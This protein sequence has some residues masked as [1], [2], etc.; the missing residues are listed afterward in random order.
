MQESTTNGLQATSGPW[1][2]WVRL[3]ELQVF[4][5]ACIAALPTL[6]SLLSALYSLAVVQ[7]QLPPNGERSWGHA[8][9][10]CICAVARKKIGGVRVPGRSSSSNADTAS[11][12]L[13]PTQLPSS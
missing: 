3:P 5:S 11:I 13:A 1:I 10:S 6:L 4:A 9:S 8:A 2:H 7:T 12:C